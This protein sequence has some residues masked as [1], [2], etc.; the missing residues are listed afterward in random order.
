MT[1]TLSKGLS[2][3]TSPTDRLSFRTESTFRF[4]RSHQFS[5]STNHGYRLP[6]PSCLTSFR[7]FLFSLLLFS[8]CSSTHAVSEIN[9]ATSTPIFIQEGN[10]VSI[11][12]S[13]SSE[14]CLDDYIILTSSYAPIWLRIRNISISASFLMGICI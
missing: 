4:K 1:V 11:D 12:S 13:C 8:C 10:Q 6:Y 3:E 9:L 14:L 5:S 7:L 2:Q